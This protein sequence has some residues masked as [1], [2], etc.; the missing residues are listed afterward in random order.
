M[1]ARASS[2]IT[3]MTQK[4]SRTIHRDHQIELVE[5]FVDTMSA[6][7]V[8]EIVLDPEELWSDPFRLLGA[9]EAAPLAGIVRK[10]ANCREW[11]AALIG[12]IL[13]YIE[14][15]SEFSATRKRRETEFFCLT[16]FRVQTCQNHVTFRGPSRRLAQ[17]NEK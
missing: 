15:I 13:L 8:K 16:A 17:R 2:A 1:I 3:D 10:L 11:N 6:S 4:R 7:N 5:L 14:R 12:S 9:V